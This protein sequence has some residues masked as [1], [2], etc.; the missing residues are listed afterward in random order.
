MV[1]DEI[2]R[3]TGF[4]EVDYLEIDRFRKQI[5]VE[6]IK[7]F[8]QFYIYYRILEIVP[9][10]LIVRGNSQFLNHLV[11]GHMDQIMLRIDKLTFDPGK[12]CVTIE[13]LNTKMQQ[14]LDKE[15]K[16]RMNSEL[17]VLN[18]SF[19]NLKKD[20][21]RIFRDSRIAHN[22]PDMNVSESV[23]NE[24]FT[25]DDMKDA[26]TF[27]FRKFDILSPYLETDH[28]FSADW[29]YENACRTIIFGKNR[30]L[31]SQAPENELSDVDEFIIDFLERHHPDVFHIPMQIL[32][33]MMTEKSFDRIV[34]DEND[35]AKI[36]KL[37]ELKTITDAE[38]ARRIQN[39]KDFADYLGSRKPNDS[40]T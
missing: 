9:F 27:A 2:L 24:V 1:N 4:S 15:R 17:K 3:K 40:E 18:S 38:K 21:I 19:P 29:A 26:L 31:T 35:L 28:V 32:R 23:R 34:F 25:I 12:D 13:K 14:K 39:S 33:S 6:L 10:R 7:L 37:R 22:I 5:Y 20:F 11:F 30:R 16:K 36:E 8:E